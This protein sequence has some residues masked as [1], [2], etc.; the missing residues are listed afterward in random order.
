MLI[1]FLLILSASSAIT[2][3][4]SSN[5]RVS[6]AARAMKSLL[7][8]GEITSESPS[9]FVST[10]VLKWVI[11]ALQKC[12]GYLFKSL[13]ETKPVFNCNYLSFIV[14]DFSPTSSFSSCPFKIWLVS[15][16]LLYLAM[17]KTGLGSITTSCGLVSSFVILSTFVFATIWKVNNELV[18]FQIWRS[19]N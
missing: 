12:Q 4:N 10:S 13:I 1:E 19:L 7:E 9:L 18:S 17:Y 11:S 2:L 8:I 14:D 6:L 15:I 3:V 16:M 5:D